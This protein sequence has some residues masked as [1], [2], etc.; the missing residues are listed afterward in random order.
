MDNLDNTV[1]LGALIGAI[2]NQSIHKLLGRYDER[3]LIPLSISGAVGG[4][5][6]AL[7][8]S[9]A[10]NTDTLSSTIMVLSSALGAALYDELLSI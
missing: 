5:L 7:L 1:L 2:A 6:G 4:G 8:A 9:T 3:L 10:F